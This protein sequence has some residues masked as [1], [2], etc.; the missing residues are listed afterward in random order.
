MTRFARMPLSR[1]LGAV[2]LGITGLTLVLALILNT[3]FQMHGYRE[4]TLQKTQALAEL[5]A[6]STAASLDFHDPQTATENLAAL[7]LV[8]HVSWAEVRDSDGTTFA[9]YGNPPASLEF[10]GGNLAN[11]YEVTLSRLVVQRKIRSGEETTGELTLGCSLD[12]QWLILGRQLGVS[13]PILLA[14]MGLSLLLVRFSQRRITFPLQRLHGAMKSIADGKDYSGRVRYAADDEIGA[15][16]GMFNAMLEEVEKRDQWL[17]SHRELL[18]QMVAT[19]THQ[20]ENKRA[21][22]A[23]KN[24]RLAEEVVVRREAEMIREE[25]ERINRHDLKS[26]LNLV[27]GYP[28]LMLRMGG[29]S[30]EHRECLHRIEAAGYRMLDM[31]R[32][33]LDLFKMEKGIYRL[34]A[35]R[36]DAVQ[37]LCG[38]EDELRPLLLKQE[39]RLSMRLDGHEVLG[40][41][42][43]LLH[44]EEGLL[45]TMFRNLLVNGIEASLPGDVVEIHLRHGTRTR[46]SICNSQPVPDPVRKRFFE[47]YV[48]H[49]KKDGTGLGTYSAALIARTHG[50][51]I[52]VRTGKQRG[53][54]LTVAFPVQTETPSTPLSPEP[55]A[56]SGSTPERCEAAT[57]KDG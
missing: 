54:V 38:L 26:S 44:G 50:A 28:E 22:L 6:A 24:R 35:T 19:R 29:L 39:V 36:L 9:V 18:E 5:M 30:E 8:P 55:D 21:E 42:Q 17:R 46:I 16:V 7:R 13:V 11:G 45:C 12:G 48:T 1:K 56:S 49:G 25:V 53:T 20:L 57:N 41:E 43:V 3:L 33:Q 10:P 31:I 27:I 23:E 52:T 37:L 51:S 14:T 2:V 34:R 15:L 40:T 47:K 4:D 32:Y